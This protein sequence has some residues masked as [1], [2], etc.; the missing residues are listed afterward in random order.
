MRP[1]DVITRNEEPNPFTGLGNVVPFPGVALP[2]L[3]KRGDAEQRLGFGVAGKAMPANSRQFR[4]FVNALK[5]LADTSL[6]DQ[7][8]MQGV[9][10]SAMTIVR[11]H[12]GS[13]DA[14]NARYLWVGVG[15]RGEDGVWTVFNPAYMQWWA[16]RD[17]YVETLDEDVIILTT[18]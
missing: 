15:A 11:I 14:G 17:E 9:D 12:S 18:M 3:P 10:P 16:V 4:T 1:P 8:R 7:D 5:T 6:T 2:G 13:D